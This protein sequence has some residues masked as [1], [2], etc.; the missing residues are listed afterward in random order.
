M[1]ELFM[2]VFE[3]RDW[4]KAQVQEQ[5]VSYSES[6]ACAILA[7]GRRPPPWLL[8]ALDSVPARGKPVSF[9][10]RVAAC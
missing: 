8:P 2:Q 6:L 5:V 9:S 3:R 7:A 4:V 1:E 10:P